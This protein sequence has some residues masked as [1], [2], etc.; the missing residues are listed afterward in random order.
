M[1]I[2]AIGL[3][4]SEYACVPVPGSGT[5]AVE[6]VIGSIGENDHL[7]VLINGAYGRRIEDIARR[8][9]IKHSSITWEENQPIKFDASKLSSEV[10]HIAIVHHETTSGIINDFKQ[11][12]G[13]GRV[14]I[15][16]SM[17]SLGGIPLDYQGLD[18][19]VAASGKCFEGPP[20]LG[21]VVAKRTALQKISANHS[22]ALDVKAQHDGMESNGQFR[23]TPPT[24]IVSA[25]HR[26]LNLHTQMGGVASRYARYVQ[27][28]TMLIDFFASE[29]CYP[30]VEDDAVRGPIITTLYPPTPQPRGT[31]NPQPYSWW[32]FEA[33]YQLLS[34]M[35]FLIY[36]GKVTSTPTFR[37]GSI[38]AL[39]AH[40]I[41][42][43]IAAASHAFS[44]IKQGKPF[45]PIPLE[46]T[47]I[48]EVLSSH[49][50]DVIGVSSASEI[51]ALFSSQVSNFTQA[52][53]ASAILEALSRQKV[54]SVF[55]SSSELGQAIDVLTSNPTS[56]ILL[57]IKLRQLDRRSVVIV[58][59][60]L[61]AAE[62]P[63]VVLNSV[64]V[65]ACVQ[66][67]AAVAKRDS[68]PFAILLS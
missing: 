14:V 32:S 34:N 52:T 28:S 48:L 10:T 1:V 58:E 61:R 9:K 4:A 2:R 62:I 15:V 57:F 12:L 40:D 49:S 24:H 35:G 47:S 22:L 3:D 51:K 59:N 60:L 50:I 55:F 25:L 64:C 31:A 17:S 20:G 41:S 66:K 33:F 21:F 56:P 19:V 37:V 26:A 11:L 16:D 45:E 5:N 27:N 23:F 29:G 18:F 67:A 54:T 53:A 68:I 39:D 6:S 8:L 30:F 44:L 36:P 63:F 13:H 65:T 7:L 46:P 43:F 42:M 38:G